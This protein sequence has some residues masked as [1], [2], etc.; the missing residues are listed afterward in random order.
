MSAARM[1]RSV[2]LRAVRLHC[3]SEMWG[4]RQAA[5][6]LQARFREDQYGD[7]AHSLRSGQND[8]MVEDGRLALGIMR[9]E[10]MDSTEAD[11]IWE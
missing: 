4:A 2:N 10:S 3:R 5:L 11:S 8:G 6:R 9:L 1:G 7:S